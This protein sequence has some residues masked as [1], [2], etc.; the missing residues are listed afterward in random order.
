MRVT[1]ALFALLASAAAQEF[2]QAFP[3]LCGKYNNSCVSMGSS[4]VSTSVDWSG[5][6]EGVLVLEQ[7]VFSDATTCATAGGAADVVFQYIGSYQDLGPLANQDTAANARWVYINYDTIEVTPQTA[8]QVASLQKACPC[9]NAADWVLNSPRILSNCDTPSGAQAQC[10][11]SLFGGTQEASSAGF[12]IGQ[13][14]FAIAQNN[15]TGF[16]WGRIDS[17]PAQAIPNW[18]MDPATGTQ[19]T[20]PAANSQVCSDP[21]IVNNYCASWTTTCATHLEDGEIAVDGTSFTESFSYCGPTPSPQGLDQGDV[22]WYTRNITTYSDAECNV[23]SLTF[24]ESGNFQTGTL[25][26]NQDQ[27]LSFQRKAASV[28]V[29]PIDADTVTQLSINCPCAIDPKNDPWTANATRTLTSCPSASC[30]FQGWYFNATIGDKAYGTIRRLSDSTHPDTLQMSLPSNTQEIG[31]TLPVTYLGGKAFEVLDNTC[32]YVTPTF[33]LCGMWARTCTAESF[34]YDTTQVLSLTGQDE[35]NGAAVF[36]K[37]F[38][39]PGG[40]CASTQSQMTVEAE[41]FWS[42][43]EVDGINGVLVNYH[44]VEVQTSTPDLLNNQQTGCPCGGTWEAGVKR[45]L[46]TC[47]DGT[48]PGKGLFGGG[49][50]GIPGYGKV[51]RVNDMLQMSKLQEK[52]EDGISNGVFQMDDFPLSL[53]Q[54][55][56]KEKVVDRV[57]GNYQQPCHPDGEYGTAITSYTSN[58]YYETKDRKKTYNLNRTDYT[59]GSGCE[60]QAPIL[61]VQQVGVLDFISATTAVTNAKAVSLTPSSLVIKPLRDDITAALNSKCPC[62]S[63]TNPWTTN[64]ARTITAAC[65]ANTCADYSWLRQPILGN[66]VPVYGSMRRM[67]DFLR[68]TQFAGDKQQGFSELLDSFDF[69]FM[70]QDDTACAYVP[71]SGSSSGGMGAGSALVIVF[72]VLVLVYVG[73]G[74]ALNFQKTQ[75]PTI[76]HVDFW[77]AFP[78][79]VVDGI[80]FAVCG[81]CGTRNSS[82]RY[83]EFGGNPDNSY[84]SL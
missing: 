19:F 70:M 32:P 75:T 54:E 11:T 53:D 3:Q 64:L 10:D 31:T 36:Y 8:A 83:Q 68:M 81:L 47:A 50:L 1:G 48:C 76:P 62:S 63:T 26:G 30:S 22:G 33:N 67:G 77:R 78:G 20:A 39:M 60:D 69:P 40:A 73:G 72:L 42:S 2:P 29:M 23:G 15:E 27:A 21:K 66:G 49:I 16:F 79:H 24:A 25:D 45:T 35:E 52:V 43:Y 56:V 6:V 80:N 51:I 61:S 82:A 9:N 71:P 34:V 28:S 14:A 17:D 74:M 84:G 57:C 5:M 58:F 41:G 18:V 13:P 4:Y 37:E 65:P 55:C 7:Q 38:F 12:I 59:P 44:S 46:T